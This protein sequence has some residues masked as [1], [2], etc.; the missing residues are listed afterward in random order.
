MY[1]YNYEKILPASLFGLCGRSSAQRLL[2]FM[3]NIDAANTY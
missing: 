2:S 3:L 1:W